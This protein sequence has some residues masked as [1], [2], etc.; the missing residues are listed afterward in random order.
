MLSAVERCVEEVAETRGESLD[1]S[2]IPLDDRRPSSRSAPP[3]RPASSRSRAAPRCRCCPAPGPK[4]RR[5]HRPGR[6]GPPRTDPGR[7]GPP[8]YRTAASAGA[9]TPSFEIPYEHPLLRDVLEDTLGTI[10]F[11]EQV[12]EVAIALAGFSPAGADSLRRAMSRKRSV[13]A[14][15]KHHERFIAGAGGGASAEAVA[16]KVWAQI[17][18]F[19]GFGFPKAHSAAFGLLAYQSAWLRVHRPPEFLCALLNEQPMGFYPPDALVHE[20]QRRG[21]RIGRSRRQPQP[22][23]LPR[24]ADRRRAHS[25]DRARLRQGRAQGG[26]GEPGRRARAQRRLRRDRRPRLPLRR[27]PRRRSEPGPALDD[28]VAE[29]LRASIPAVGGA[30]GGRHSGRSGAP[31][32][33]CA[34]ARTCRWRCRSSRRGRPNSSRST[35]GARRSPT[36]ARSG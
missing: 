13:E 24:R 14:I 16:E 32:L 34:T 17:Q 26:G 25:A 10:V 23:P 36:T 12:I 22:R 6:A 31:G 19:S 29:G 20:A 28:L 21:V 9:R 7:R 8:I 11:Q 33:G 27:W 30:G 4:P 35:T 18:G 15:E 2:R 1:L 3:R 5:P